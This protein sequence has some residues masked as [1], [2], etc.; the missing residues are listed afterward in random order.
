MDEIVAA[1]AAQI[2]RNNAP[3]GVGELA[4][5]GDL[6]ALEGP[7][8]GAPKGPA[9]PA[10]APTA[11]ALAPVAPQKSGGKALLVIAAILALLVAAG[12]TF[13]V[14]RSRAG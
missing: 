1:A 8:P 5:P 10:L 3:H 11:L 4:A 2:A 6:S 14:L 9:N 7:P 12:V 13:L